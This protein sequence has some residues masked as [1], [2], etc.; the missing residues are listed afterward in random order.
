MLVVVVVVVVVVQY[1]LILYGR[2]VGGRDSGRRA[3]AYARQRWRMTSEM[4]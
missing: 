1:L 4:R 3:D 2:F